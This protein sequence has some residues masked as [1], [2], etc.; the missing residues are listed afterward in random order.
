[1]NRLVAL[2]LLPKGI[3]VGVKQIGAQIITLGVL[4]VTFLCVITGID[5]YQGS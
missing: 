5:S 1:M 3:L 4:A 2:S